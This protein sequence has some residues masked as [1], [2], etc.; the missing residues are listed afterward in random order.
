MDNTVAKQAF[1][2]HIC[3]FWQRFET[4]LTVTQKYSAFQVEVTGRFGKRL[5]SISAIRRTLKFSLESFYGFTLVKDN[6]S[7]M[8]SR[9]S[10]ENCMELEKS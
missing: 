10:Y 9:L 8:I 3:H 7:L 5:K 2:S 6:P 4:T 1:G